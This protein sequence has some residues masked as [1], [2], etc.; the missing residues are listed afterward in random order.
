MNLLVR[1][2][3]EAAIVMLALALG[4]VFLWPGAASEGLGGAV[5]A[6]MPDSGVKH[7]VTAVLLNFRGYDTLLEMLVLL[8]ALI[9]VRSL[10]ELPV[11][12]VP[13]S[14]SPVLR[15]LLRFLTPFLLLVSIYL[16]WRGSS[17]PGGAF[18][19]GAVLGAAGVLWLLAERPVNQLPDGRPVRP[20]LVTGVGFFAIAGMV[21]A[22]SE[23]AFLAYPGAHAGTLIFAIETLATI[24]I[25]ATLLVL[26]VG[27]PTSNP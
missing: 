16:L 21:L 10:G 5:A 4:A 1:L 11:S 18:Q 25:A 9:G 15:E 7:P 13:D 6:A 8:L 24:S 22:F 3:I 12:A 14:P 27:A 23:G 2:V 26:F 19:A 17:G 20:L